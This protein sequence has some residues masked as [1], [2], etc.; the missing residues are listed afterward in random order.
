MLDGREYRRIITINGHFPGPVIR[1]LKHAIVKVHV[2][3]H[4]PLQAAS[5]HWHGILQTN[6]YWMDG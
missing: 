2:K 1:V 6:N 5:I 3:N 4:M